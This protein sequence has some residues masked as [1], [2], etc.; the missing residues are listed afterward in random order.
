MSAELRDL[1]TKVTAETHVWLEAVHRVTGKDVA[2]IVRNQL[3]E[4]ALRE[5]RIAS[6]AQALAKA[7]GITG[8]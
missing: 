1:R 3:H 4:I 7:E 8:H 2:E 6:V 5:L